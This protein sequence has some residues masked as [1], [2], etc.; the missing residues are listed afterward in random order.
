LTSDLAESLGLD[1]PSGAMV[2][3]VH[4]LGPARRAGLQVGDVVVSIDDKA[5]Q[6][7][8]ALQYR[9]VTKG[10]GGKAKLGVYRNHKTLTATISLIAP[11]EDPPRNTQEL[12]G[13]HPLAGSKVA[14][15]SPAVAQELG[16]DDDSKQGVVVIEVARGTNA[17][18]LG[19]RQGDIVVGINNEEVSTVKQLT[20][21]LQLDTGG[22][23]LSVE[24]G[25]KV[26]NLA[27]QG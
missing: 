3:S 11:I 20:L 9:F 26:F 21:L 23:R 25:G 10:V 5:V 24:R 6:D 22:W 8:E 12:E 1:R 18:R 17:N 15:L 19:L 14:N 27:I 13:R 7:P 16:M 4:Q 2:T